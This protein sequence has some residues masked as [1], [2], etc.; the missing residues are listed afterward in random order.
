MEAS[1]RAKWAKGPTHEQKIPPHL[2]VLASNGHK[3]GAG[4]EGLNRRTPRTGRPEGRACATEPCCTTMVRGLRRQ[5]PLHA[6]AIV[7]G[8]SITARKKGAGRVG[9]TQGWKG[10]AK[11]CSAAALTSTTRMEK[12][13]RHTAP[14]RRKGR[15]S[16]KI[17]PGP[18]GPALNT[19][20]LN[21]LRLCT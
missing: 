5:A 6:R 4:V 3:I 14:N 2:G 13:V 15:A 18:S 16:A 10:G 12:C 7:A 9:N 17:E 1:T 20:A 21:P 11:V 8:F 19:K